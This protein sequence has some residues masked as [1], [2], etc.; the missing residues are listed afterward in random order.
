MTS[1]P[2]WVYPGILGF[3]LFS[4]YQEMP[5]NKWLNSNRVLLCFEAICTFSTNT[6]FTLMTYLP[7]RCKPGADVIN[8]F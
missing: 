2:R 1:A 3:S 5:V 6:N 7:M 8:K 4:S